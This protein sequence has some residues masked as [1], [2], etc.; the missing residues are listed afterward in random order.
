MCWA[1]AEAVMEGWILSRQHTLCCAQSVAL[2]RLAATSCRNGCVCH[3]HRRGCEVADTM[4]GCVPGAVLLSTPCNQIL[5]PDRAA[6]PMRC[7]YTAFSTACRVSLL[8]P[9]RA[10]TQT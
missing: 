8:P 7:A 2:V 9:C 10:A 4:P 1:R 5:T 3:L 6:L